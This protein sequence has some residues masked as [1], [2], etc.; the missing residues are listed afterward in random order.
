MQVDNSKYEQLLV[1]T[2]GPIELWA[3]STTP[4]DTALRNRLYD[5]VGFSEALRRLSKVFPT[6]SALKEIERRK[7][8]RLRGGEV[9]AR[10]QTGVID[11]L[12]DE[13]IDGRGSLLSFDPMLTKRTRWRSPPN[14]GVEQGRR[15][16][17]K[18][19]ISYEFLSGGDAELCLV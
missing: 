19:R 10:A 17:G 4:G 18:K 6:G 15:M 9:D 8:D 12:A 11:D 13:L 14:S 7:S 16:R 2:L 5:K 1:N 3:L